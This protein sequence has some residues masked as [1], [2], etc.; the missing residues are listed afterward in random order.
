MRLP[1]IQVISIATL[2]W[3]THLSAQPVALR[4]DYALAIHG[5]AGKVPSA[6]EWR[7]ARTETLQQALKSG[8]EMLKEGAASLDVVE[9]VIRV[10]EDSP[11]FNAGKGAVFNQAGGHELDASIMDGRTRGCGGVGGVRTIRHPISLARLV[12][13]ET[14]HV[15]LVTDGAEK[16]AD[17][18][19]AKHHLE[20][21]DNTYFSTDHRRR[22]LLRMQS[23]T[24]A[25][26]LDSKGTVGCVALDRHGNL[27]AGTSTGGLTNKRFGRI[28]DSPIV[29]AGTFADNA[30]CAVSCTG[31]GEDFIR[32]AVA[33]DVSARMAYRGDSLG[34]AVEAILHDA[35]HKVRGGIIAVGRN[36]DITMQFNTEGMAR[37]A[38]DSQG[39]FEV[40]AGD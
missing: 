9:T 12:M 39:R 40:H 37:A 26:G 15:L 22:E 18:M 36:G 32:N 31:V 23:Q 10:L 14:R 2:V 5:G 7:T 16:F 30:T 34:V 29:A 33:Y 6:E 25:D 20:R 38:A 19:E 24:A 17:E 27:A 35:D 13:T 8:S 11:Y 28:G 21:V 1:I 3:V 4:G